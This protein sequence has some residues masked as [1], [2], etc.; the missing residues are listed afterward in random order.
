MISGHIDDAL[1]LELFTHKGVGTLI[2]PDPIQTLRPA[3]PDD[4]SGIVRLLEPLESEGVLVKRNRRLLEREISHFIVIEHDG[5]VIACAALYP[6]PEERSGELAGL[7][8]HPDFRSQGAGERLL[9]EI[10]A[11]A[12]R[13]KLKRLFVLTTRAEH[14][15][16]ERGFTETGI[17]DLPGP[18]RELYNYQRRSVVLV[19]RI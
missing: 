7:A 13:S 11:R 10:E 2:T 6:F 1:L 3:R 9:K 5:V 15:F 4:I 17:D 19:K 8:V 16:V 14:W 12:R 18:K